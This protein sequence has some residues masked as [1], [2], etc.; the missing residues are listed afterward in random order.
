MEFAPRWAGQGHTRQDHAEQVGGIEGHNVLVPTAATFS[1]EYTVCFFLCNVQKKAM[2]ASGLE[3]GVLVVNISTVTGTL[4]ARTV[5]NLCRP[6][7][8]EV[9][10]TILWQRLKH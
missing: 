9:T 3:G 7:N 6:V 4:E 5:N 10:N 8:T 2:A 1:E